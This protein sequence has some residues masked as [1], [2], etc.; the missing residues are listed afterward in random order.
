VSHEGK[1]KEKEMHNGTEDGELE[2]EKRKE[3]TVQGI[4]GKARVML[5]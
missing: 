1:C 5:K 3:N 4:R 2:E